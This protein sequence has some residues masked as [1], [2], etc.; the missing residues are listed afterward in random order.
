MIPSVYEAARDA[1]KVIK[2]LNAEPMLEVK[3]ERAMT[4]QLI[5]GGNIY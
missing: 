1:K 2:A 3:M 5:R 4:Y